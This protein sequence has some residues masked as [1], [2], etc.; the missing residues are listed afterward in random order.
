MSKQNTRKHS[1]RKFGSD[2]PLNSVY[3]VILA[4]G[5]GSRFWPLSRELEPKQFLKLHDNKSL[6]EHTIERLMPSIPVRQIYI[7]SNQHYKFEIENQ[8]AGFSLPKE[9]I[10]LEPEGKNTAPAIGLAASILLEKDPQ[11][12]MV[13]LP[14]DHFIRDEKNFLTILKQAEALARR[15]YLVTLGITPRA[16]HTGYGYI[17]RKAGALKPQ[18]NAYLIEQF[19]EKPERKRAELF[20][21]D[22]NYFWNSGIFAWKSSVILK[23]I[24]RHL[25]D[26]SKTLKALGPSPKINTSLWSRIKPI[27][28]DY[29]ILEKSKKAAVIVA[30]D[31][32]WSD[33]GSWAALG[34][35]LPR[36]KS[37]NS[38]QGDCIDLA[39]K[40]ISVWGGKHLIATIGLRNLFI[41]DTPDAL[42]VCDKDNTEA[43]KK[44]VEEIK[45][46][47]RQEH[48]AH[49]TVKRPWGSYTVI[50]TA[51]GFKVKEV[52]INPHRRL[53]LQAHTRRS[54]HW[55]V[56][57]GEAK[58]TN[59]D[60]TY[61]LSA[62]ESTYI[63][64]GTKH[65][66]ENLHD[67]ALKIIEVQ[68]GH[69]LEEDDIE[70]FED[71]FER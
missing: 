10:I 35:F 1:K 51:L 15:D 71:D 26:L 60:K 37:G 8:V 39:S 52:H 6:L 49:N 56:V 46:R 23:E 55:I 65:R 20:F 17:K 69:Y 13:V 34:E 5:V 18:A 53:S 43:V 7:I 36:D 19:C 59:G 21:Q 38:F 50:N 31:I 27:S 24:G 41:V 33:L 64:K 67:Q 44:I 30:Q 62:N 42:L 68:C 54:E 70:R 25:P 32:G 47:G 14:A 22:K 48:I 16:P 3:A 58:I 66:L 63:S 9:N 28:V 45:K 2:K 40:N 12:I 4:G 29:G 57:E 11:S 61:Y